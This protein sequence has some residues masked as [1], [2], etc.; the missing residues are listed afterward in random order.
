MLNK[1]KKSLLGTAAVMVALSPL[2]MQNAQAAQEQVDAQAT[3]NRVIDLTKVADI[4]FGILT[5]TAAGT[6]AV[7]FANG[8]TTTAG[9][10]HPAGGTVTSGHVT[11]KAQSGATVQISSTPASFKITTGG[12]GANKSMTVQNIVYSLT[13]AGA[14]GATVTKT[15]AATTDQIKIGAQLKSNGTQVTGVYTGNYNVEVVY[16]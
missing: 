10:L 9:G 16:P 13:G 6:V 4:N 3:I 8:I 11:I 12:G 15:M 2:A 1:N 14:T 5:E 7:D